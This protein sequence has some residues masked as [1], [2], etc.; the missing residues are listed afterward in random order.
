MPAQTQGQPD[1][2]RTFMGWIV[3]VVWGLKHATR[4]YCRSH[5]LGREQ[6][7]VESKLVDTPHYPPKPH[8]DG[9]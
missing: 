3:D 4:V 7:P 1:P 5:G 9:D 2:R 8:A 6:V